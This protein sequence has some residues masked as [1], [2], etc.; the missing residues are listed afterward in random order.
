M[1][2][3]ETA[4]LTYTKTEKRTRL[5]Q[6]KGVFI[7]RHITWRMHQS[8]SRSFRSCED[9][10]D[11]GVMLLDARRILDGMETDEVFSKTR[12]VAISAGWR[13]RRGSDVFVRSARGDWRGTVARSK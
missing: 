10:G 2:A 5:L 13:P 4:V 1:V 9:A 3:T 8:P 6:M 11:E 12:F 7:D